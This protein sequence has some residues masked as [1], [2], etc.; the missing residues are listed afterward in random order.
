MREDWLPFTGYAFDLFS[1]NILSNSLFA[2]EKKTEGIHYIGSFSRLLR[3]V[4]DNSENNV[5]SLSKEWETIDLYIQLE[6]PGMDTQ[7][8]YKK[9][10]HGNS[11]TEFEKY[12]L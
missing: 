6:T 2:N 3:Q 1:A 9:L 12:H 8:S 7:L 4:P 5:I 11:I 10:I